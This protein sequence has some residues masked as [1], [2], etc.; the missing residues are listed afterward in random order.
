MIT[1]F[2]GADDVAGLRAPLKDEEPSIMLVKG[3]W[4]L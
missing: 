1:Y 3:F 4:E 2:V